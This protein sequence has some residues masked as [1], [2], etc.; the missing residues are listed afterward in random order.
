L[1]V[2][3]VRVCVGKSENGAWNSGDEKAEKES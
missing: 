1:E 2:G 3:S